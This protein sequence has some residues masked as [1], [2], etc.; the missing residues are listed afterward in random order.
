MHSNASSINMQDLW[1]KFLWVIEVAGFGICQ[2]CE[3]TAQREGF[4]AT[5]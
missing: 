5:Y 3:Y 4:T 1:K 2:F